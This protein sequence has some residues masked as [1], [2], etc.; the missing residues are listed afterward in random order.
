MRKKDLV[1]LLGGAAMALPGVTSARAQDQT[2]QPPAEQPRS[3]S[4]PTG[5]E[6]ASTSQGDIVV[7]AQ[8]REERLQDVPLAV[9]ALGGEFLGR[10]GS[11]DLNDAVRYAPGVSITSANS[12]RAGGVRIRGVGTASFSEG[13]T[14]SVATIVDGVVFGRQAQGQFQ[15]NDVERVEVLRGPQGVLFGA[16]ATAGAINVVTARPSATPEANADVQFASRGE[17]VVRGSASGPLDQDGALRVR[18]SG[19]RSK[20]DGDVTNLVSGDRLNGRD[21]FGFRGKLE[22]QAGELVNILVTA[23]YFKQTPDCCVL[24]FRET[25]AP[26]L[27]APVVASPRNRQ[28]ALDTQSSF[29]RSRNWG[30][31]GEVN[32]DLGDATLTSISG[33]RNWRFRDGGDVDFTSL[34][35]VPF[36]G[37]ENRTRQISQE[38]RLASG[39]GPVRYLVGGFYFDQRLRANTL[40]QNALPAFIIPTITAIPAAFRPILVN[41]LGEISETADRTVR[42]Q[43]LAAFGQLD[44]DLGDRV[45]L[46]GGL[47]YTDFNLGLDFARTNTSRAGTITPTTV[48]AGVLPAS[49]FVILG[50]PTSFATSNDDTNLS[51]RATATFKV[52]PDVNLYASYSRGYKGPAVRADSGDPIAGPDVAL[53]SRVRPETVDAFEVGLRSQFLDKRV[54]LNITGFLSKFQHFQANTVNPNAPTQQVLT[55]AGDVKTRGVEVE[56]AVKPSRRF[57]FGG[58]AAYVRA[59]Y[60]DILV[61]CSNNRADPGCVV[62][63]GVPLLNLRGRQFVNAPKFS[64]NLFADANVRVTDAVEVFARADLQTRSRVNYAFNQ[65]PIARQGAYALVNGSLGV[66]TADGR[67]SVGVFARNLF[68]KDYAVLVA[69]SAI[70]PTSYQLLGE[71]RTIGILASMHF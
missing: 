54:T 34:R 68:D 48:I 18:L 44:V 46:T 42:T 17:F 6:N 70:I 27:L 23:D 53:T 16:S 24:T 10:L 29:Q 32:V 21:E 33:Y 13:V 31:V 65:D 36:A 11:R 28:I 35:V 1:T 64:F 38:V 37:T 8:L 49:G 12:A 43:Q 52:T 63:G 69:R 62:T 55:D 20:R 67:Y 39:P 14:G 7:T 47:R 71:P 66:Q 61:N 45:T 30:V 19:Y 9:T 26:G 2:G 57:N 59:T 25:S 22:Y 56:F 51:G 3:P 60:G 4:S 40:F 41:A 5:D 50:A 15:L 58:N